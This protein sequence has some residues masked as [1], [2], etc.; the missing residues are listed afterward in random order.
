MQSQLDEPAAVGMHRGPAVGLGMPDGVVVVALPV[1]IA[2]VYEWADR[3][4]RAQLLECL[5]QPLGPL[6]LVAVADGAF[7]TFVHRPRWHLL[8]VSANEAQEFSGGQLRE[9]AEFALEIDS[10]LPERIDGLLVA[11]MERSPASDAALGTGPLQWT[12][13]LAPCQR[14]NDATH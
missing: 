12:S 9:L 14:F 3:P 4:L 5:L 2:Q 13:T 7:G 11:R 1:L 6:A 10:G 8:N